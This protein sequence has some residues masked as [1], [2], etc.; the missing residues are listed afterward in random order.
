MDGIEAAGRI[1]AQ[2]P[3]PVVYISASL[4]DHTRRRAQTTEPAGYLQ[5][6]VIAEALR[7]TLVRALG[8]PSEGRQSRT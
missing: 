2:V 3:I 6:P 8:E 7:Q 1:Q 5:K 4:D